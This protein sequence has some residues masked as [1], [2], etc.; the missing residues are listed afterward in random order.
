MDEELKSKKGT[1]TIGIVALIAAAVHVASAEVHKPRAV[2]VV[3]ALRARPVVEVLVVTTE[4][5]STSLLDLRI[6]HLFSFRNLAVIAL[7]PTHIL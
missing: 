7:S 5:R 4:N 1:H 2:A 6:Q 3:A